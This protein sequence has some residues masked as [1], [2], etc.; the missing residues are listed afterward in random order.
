MSDP[1]CDGCGERL[2]VLLCHKCRPGAA[3]TTPD[4]SALSPEL[5]ALKSQASVEEFREAQIYYVKAL[6][7]VTDELERVTP[8]NLEARRQKIVAVMRM[9]AHW[10]EKGD[11]YALGVAHQRSVE[12]PILAD[13]ER[14]SKLIDEAYGTSEYQ[15]RCVALA[16]IARHF[17]RAALVDQTGEKT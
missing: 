7:C 12:A 14:A 15:V 16:L 6:G 2:L 3:M 4:R 1:K 9:A 5:P 17:L 8:E 13:M 11:L 10:F